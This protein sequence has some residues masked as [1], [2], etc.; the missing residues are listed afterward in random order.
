MV[1]TTMEN[2]V[3]FMDLLKMILYICFGSQL[4]QQKMKNKSYN[5]YGIF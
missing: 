2:H 4:R 5:Y 3:L 1:T